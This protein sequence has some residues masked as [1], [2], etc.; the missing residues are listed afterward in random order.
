[1]PAL[2]PSLEALISMP[3]MVPDITCSLAALMSVGIISCAS[4]ENGH[5]D[6]SMLASENANTR[7]N[8]PASTPAA[9]T[10][11]EQGQ[12]V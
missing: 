7:K 2:S 12:M 10:I 4:E 9:S 11:Q 6:S 5:A 1:M 8:R 3:L